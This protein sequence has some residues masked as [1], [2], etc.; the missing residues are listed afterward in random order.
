MKIIC[1][2]LTTIIFG[3]T[4]SA[5]KQVLTSSN[6]DHPSFVA[7]GM[8][9]KKIDLATFR[10]KVVVINLWFVNCPNCIEEIQLLNQL[11]DDYKG[12]DVVFLG[13]AASSKQLIENFIAKN[14]FKYQIIP[15]AQQIIIGKFG[16][17]DKHGNINVPFPMHYMLDREG[18]V[19]VK[20]QGIKGIDGV[21]TELARQFASKTPVAK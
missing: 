15:N 8:D 3:F 10:G 21:K 2:C 5:Q 16:T 14:P 19:V 13:L 11:V 17:P 12:K 6:A 9:G 1:I 20:E 18:K 7:A 4:A